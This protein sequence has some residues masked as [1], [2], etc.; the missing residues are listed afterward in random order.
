MSKPNINIPTEFAI[1]GNKTDFSQAK[2]TN[3]FDRLQPDVLPGDNLNKFIDDTYKGLNGVLELYEGCVLYDSTVTYTNKSLIFDITNDGIKFYHSL[4]NGN[5]NHALTDTDYW[6][7]VNLG[8]SSRNIGEVVTSTI[9]LTDAGLHL[10]DGALISGSGSYAEFVTYISGYV[11]T[12]PDI[13]TTENNWQ[14]AVS[15]YG[16]CGKFVYDSVNNTVRLPKYNSK[17]YTGGGNAPVKGNGIALGLTNGA[18]NF[19]LDSTGQSGH[20]NNVPDEY[21]TAV[22]TRN[23]TLVGNIDGAIGLSTDGTKS[24]II[25]DLANITTALDGYYYIVVATLT[26]TS[27]QVDIDEIATDLNGK[28]DT[29]LSNTDDTAKILMSRMAMPSDTYDNLTLGASGSTYTAPANGWFFYTKVANNNNQYISL[30]NITNK[31]RIEN[32]QNSGGWCSVYLP[33]LKGQVVE[34]DYDAG[35][36]LKYFRFVYAKGSESEVS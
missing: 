24:G 16:V 32:K 22:G 28:A 29:D 20:P 21:G 7:E 9:P 30:S 18:T 12:N 1:N 15:T 25:A 4:Q 19:A 6:E 14:T 35:G 5:I 23:G 13:F 33:V 34:V 31:I 11:L 3:G 26:K 8:G 36:E 17:I 10:L 2:I 27:I